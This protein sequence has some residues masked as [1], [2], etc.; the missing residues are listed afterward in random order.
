LKIVYSFNKKGAEGAHW[1][2]EIALAS[3]DG[4]KFIPFNHHR[5]LDPALYADAYKLDCLYRASDPRLNKLYAEF[6]AV[7]RSSGADAVIVAN[8]PPYH[9]DFLKGLPIYKALYGADDPPSSYLINIPY[10]HAYDHVFFANPM[11]SGQMDMTEK[12]R[13]AGKVRAD[14]LPISVFDF[15]CRPE[16]PTDALLARDRDI[17]LIYI[18][19]FWRQKIDALARIRRAFGRRFRMYGFFRLKHNV[20]INTFHGYGG[21]VNPVSLPERVAL[22]QRAKIGVNLHYD[23]FTLGNQRLYHLPANGVMQI[24]DCASGMSRVYEPGSEIIACDDTDQI[25]DSVRHYL[26]HD[27]Q[28]RAIAAAGHRR[29]MRDYRF[30]ET[31]RRAGKLMKA[32]LESIRRSAPGGV[33]VRN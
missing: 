21:W 14:W 7:V 22:Y 29:V 1:E 2:K 32:G 17:D 13:Y 6:S 31:T 12:M 3:N 8:C 26:E 9:P 10:L 20:Y 23:Q 11:Y 19:S 25:I 15:E 18:G 27:D 4:F 16:L 33:D 28:R 30:R 5:Y 24:S